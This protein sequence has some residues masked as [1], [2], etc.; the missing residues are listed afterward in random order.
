MGEN[1]ESDSSTLEK[2]FVCE[3]FVKIIKG[4]VEP[5]ELLSCY[6]QVSL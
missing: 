6:D 4:I 1:Q 5:D 2:D 3:G